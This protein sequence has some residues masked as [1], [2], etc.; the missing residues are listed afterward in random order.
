MASGLPKPLASAGWQHMVTRRLENVSLEPRPIIVVANFL[1]VGFVLSGFFPEPAV[2]SE[3]IW[4]EGE[5]YASSS[6]NQHGWYQNTN[7]RKDL[8][9]PG[10]SGVSGGSWHSHFTGG[11]APEYATATYCFNIAE[12]G[13]YM[14]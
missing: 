11:G 8:L 14:W 6:F 7:I 3:A 12:G 9:S 4:I 5:D 2:G 13:T 1:L 10:R